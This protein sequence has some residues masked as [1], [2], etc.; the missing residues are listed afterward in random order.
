MKTIAML[1]LAAFS[2]AAASMLALPGVAEAAKTAAQCRYDY[3]VCD[4]NCALS[5]PSCLARCKSVR[6]RCLKRAF[7][8]YE[9]PNSPATPAPVGGAG[10][11]PCDPPHIRYNNGTCGCP[12]GLTGANC[13]EI[14]V[15]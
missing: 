5:P 10:S 1:L 2:T 3:D 15:H 13:D 7:N 11:A 9:I 8:V 12:S 14:V 6:D 4:V